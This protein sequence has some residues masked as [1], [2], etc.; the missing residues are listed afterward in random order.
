MLL[1]GVL[2][3]L[4]IADDGV[5]VENDVVRIVKV[6]DMPQKKSAPHRH[7]VNRVMIYLDAGDITIAY[8]DG[9]KDQ[10][11]WKANQVVW[12]LASGQHTSENVGSAPVRIVEVELRK[13]APA[14][15]PVRNAKLDPV[16]IDP[17]HN[18][19]LFEN[20]QVRVFRSWRESGATEM[21]HEHT[22]AGRAAVLLTDLDA[23]V[24]L[25][26]GTT[27]AQHGKAGDVLWSGSVIHASTN[28]GAKKFEMVVVEVK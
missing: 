3:S 5:V 17:A 22:G 20:G 10:Q 12:S 9:H 26:D 7:D 24:R 18:V 8:E 2:L 13:P 27:S 16:A 19:L 28:V 25:A 15:A 14:A 4:L 11:H 23:S 1:F 21:M 6:T